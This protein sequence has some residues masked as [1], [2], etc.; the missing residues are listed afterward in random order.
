MLVAEVVAMDKVKAVARAHKTP[1]QQPVQLHLMAI[2]MNRA[3]PSLTMRE[4]KEVE[5]TDV[6]SAAE[7]MARIAADY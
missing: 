4:M 5:G 6:D 3:Q 7:L 2:F 1:V